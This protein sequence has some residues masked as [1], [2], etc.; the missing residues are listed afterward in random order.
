MNEVREE[1]L[2][3]LRNA[4]EPMDSLQV[5]NKCQVADR[6]D[7]SAELKNLVTQGILKRDSKKRYSF[8]VL[9]SQISSDTIDAA[10]E[11]VSLFNKLENKKSSS[12]ALVVIPQPLSKALSE[13]ELALKPP[14][15][16][17]EFSP[18]IKMAALDQL[19][20]ILHPEIAQVLMEVKED[21]ER[22]SKVG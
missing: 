17:S 2:S 13:L 20:R 3:A 10:N 1:I 8:D 22:I 9:L 16:D 6:K 7:V 5:F 18:E 21:I 15:N 14:A 4:N 12:S 19:A 11:S